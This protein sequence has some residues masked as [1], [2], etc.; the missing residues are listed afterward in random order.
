MKKLVLFAMIFA[1]L[2]CG[3]QKSGTPPGG[4]QGTVALSLTGDSNTPVAE[5]NGVP[6][7]EAELNKE[8]G[9]RLSRIKTQIF[10]IQRQGLN[11]IIDQKLL[12][13]AAK[14]AGLSVPDLIKKEVNE[15]VGEI[16]DKE[17]SDFYEQNKVRFK[18][19]TLDDVKGTLKQQLVARKASV[20]RTNF[21]DRLKDSADIKILIQRPIID[22][23]VDDD[24]M[25]GDK[26]AVVT[27]IEFTDYQCPFCSRARPTVN[28][29][30]EEYKDNV[31][32][33]LRDYPLNF[34]P[35]A[36]KAA[37]AAQCAGDQDKYWEYSNIL[38]DNQRALDLA[39]LKKYAQQ[40][41]LKQAEFDQCLD[42]GKFEAEVQKDFADGAKAGVSGTPSFFINGQMITGAR[43]FEQFKEIIDMEIREKKGKS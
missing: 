39:D 10:D 14:K 3:A 8:I 36:Q 29:I 4:S 6:I 19:K 40:V 33:V 23:S 27:I 11:A 17:V 31:R 42:S 28:R 13:E 24:P 25:R 35:F 20:Y 5:L 38:W 2:G 30:I 7:T 12:D 43:P 34:H 41:G 22:V 18:G 26:D 1:L 32:Y 15:K 37:E 9:N 21:L 16:S